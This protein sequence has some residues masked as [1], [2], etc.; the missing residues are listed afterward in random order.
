MYGCCVHTYLNTPKTFSSYIQLFVSMSWRVSWSVRLSLPLSAF[1]QDFKH[2]TAAT[3]I[4]LH[5]ANIVLLG[6]RQ[7]AINNSCPAQNY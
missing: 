1:M 2:A 4:S 6:L 7:Q 5:I 3:D